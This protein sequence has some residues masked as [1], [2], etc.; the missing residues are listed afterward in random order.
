MDKQEQVKKQPTRMKIIVIILAALLVLSAGGLAGRY[1][2]L[3]FF[4][5]AHSTATV[6]DN[7]IGEEAASSPDGDGTASSVPTMNDGRGLEQPSDNKTGGT[8]VSS[9]PA[10][11]KPAAPKLELYEG[12]PEDS[13]R[14]EV[15]NMF[16]GDV[17][18]TYF[19]VKAYHD[20]DIG[21]FFRTDI[22]EQTK[23]LGKMLH[24]K[25]THMET[26]RVLC[27]APFAE[28]DGMELSEPLKE[29]AADET[30]A[31]YRIDVSLD[32]SAGNGYQAA[33]L[34]ADFAWYV[35]DEGGL[36]P[37][38]T[39]STTHRILWVILAASSFTLLLLL[40]FWGRKEARHE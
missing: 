14:F 38:P 33:L 27:D 28:I 36:T 6:P 25:V 13:G 40:A 26:G 7:L 15:Q 18:T 29:S 3:A 34:K 24:I 17:E 11:D 8:P 31:Y 19:C 35:K 16:P 4:A 5:P 10:A 20:T 32:T 21:L 9:R 22:T 1:I 12:K 2:Y 37:P 23:N 30:I 39:G